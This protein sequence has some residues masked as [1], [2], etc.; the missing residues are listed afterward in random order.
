MKRAIVFL[1]LAGFAATLSAQSVAD[2]ARRERERRESLKGRRSPIITNEDL[3][4]IT[5]RPAIEISAPGWDVLEADEPDRGLG[6]EA[7]A[8]AGAVAAAPPAADGTSRRITPRVTDPGPSLMGATE[9]TDQ[10]RADS[11]PLK[12][13]FGRPKSSSTSWRPSWPPSS[14][15][16]SSRTIWSRTTSSKKSSTTPSSAFRR[17]RSRKPASGPRPERRAGSKGP[18]ANPTADAYRLLSILFF[19]VGLLFRAPVA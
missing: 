19:E 5:K 3:L 4:R 15:S 6:E 11:G 14:R 9:S 7:A 16:M 2:L 1:V 8:G 18:P 12:P 10:P 13:S 17:P